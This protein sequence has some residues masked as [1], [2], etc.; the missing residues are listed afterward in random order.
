[1]TTHA[2]TSVGVPAEVGRARGPRRTRGRSDGRRQPVGTVHPLAWWAWALGVAVALTRTTNPLVVA[3]LLG[4]VVL[5]VLARRGDTPWARAFGAY[6]VLG[7]VV[8]LVRVGFYVLV[9]LDDASPVVVHLPAVALPEWV[10][11]VE[12]LGPVH[13]AGL[14]GAA[15]G[16]LRLAALIVCFGAANALA[17]PKRALRS[18]PASLHHLGTAVVIAVTVTPQLVG[19]VRR[20]RRAQRL[21]GLDARGPRAAVAR[22]VPVLQ[23]ALDHA[24]VL[25]ASMDSRGYARS[26]RPGGDPWV[27]AALVVALLA[28]LLGTYGLLDATTPGWLGPALLGLGALAAVAASLVAGRRVHRTRYRPDPWRRHETALAACGVLAAV[29][30]A[31]AAALDPVGMSDALSPLRWPELPPLGVVATLLAV[32]PAVLGPGRAR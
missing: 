18:L 1:M 26:A 4:A 32:V 14:L 30:T 8:V 9:G 3:G 28:G 21:R 16:G 31:A 17:N 10:A 2:A 7:V 27:G 20:V 15:Y 12:L 6:L 29:C 23:D 22:L 13:A 11:S 24:L 19:A 5:V 25:A